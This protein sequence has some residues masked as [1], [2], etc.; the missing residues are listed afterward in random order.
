M[1]CRACLVEN[2]ELFLLDETTVSSFNCLT[3]LDV[4][5]NDKFPQHICPECYSLLIKF[6]HFR[7]TCIFSD[8]VLKK[9]SIEIK[10][11]VKQEALDSNSDENVS[12]Y[13]DCVVTITPTKDNIAL[14]E[15]LKIEKNDVNPQKKRNLTRN[16]STVKSQERNKKKCL[17]TIKPK[18]KTRKGKEVVVKSEA[19]YTCGLCPETFNAESIYKKHL[20][21]HEE[22]KTCSICPSTFEDKYQMLAHR[23]KHLPNREKKCYICLK[24]FRKE[25]HLEFHYK[26][27][28]SNETNVS[29]KCNI[30]GKTYSSPRRLRKHELIVHKPAQVICDYCKKIFGHKDILRVHIEK[31]MNRKRFICQL[32]HYA[33]NYG[34]LLRK[35]HIDKHTLEKVKCKNC[36]SVFKDQ[37]ALERHLLKCKQRSPTDICPVCGKAILRSSRL[38]KHMESHSNVMAYKCDRCPAA[39]KSRM[40]LRVHIDK[41]DGIRRFKCEYCPM[42]FRSDTVLIKHRR[43]HTGIKP[44]VCKICQKGF[45]GNHNLKVHM[46]VHGITNL[47]NKKNDKEE[48][49]QSMFTNSVI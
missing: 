48:Q 11:E 1:K 12:N 26:K 39:Y 4:K 19:I 22:M 3:S 5:I 7:D 29:C 21:K 45:T 17:S 2:T 8:T 37:T 14:S 41:H 27:N 43:V 6:L 47:I 49:T 34:A 32:C 20:E 24:G 46:K 25:I 28:H 40:A 23:L 9:G 16:Q 18:I 44:Y 30:C 15:I 38:R 13:D 31:H 36:G 33:T 35:H 10:I 42:A